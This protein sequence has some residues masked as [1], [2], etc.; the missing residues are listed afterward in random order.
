MDEV[1]PVDEWDS[2]G[3][4][5]D[6]ALATADSRYDLAAADASYTTN[7]ILDGVQNFNATEVISGLVVGSVGS[8]YH[9]AAYG[10]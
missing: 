5:H 6:Y 3:R 2:Y 8:L 9:Q 7:A 10:G 1:E 4:D